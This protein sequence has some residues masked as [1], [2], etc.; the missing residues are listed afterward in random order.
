MKFKHYLTSRVRSLVSSEESQLF[1]PPGSIIIQLKV[2]LRN[3]VQ[4]EY[5]LLAILVVACFQAV[6]FVD[7]RYLCGEYEYAATRSTSPDMFTV[8]W[9]CIGALFVSTSS[10]NQAARRR[11]ACPK[12][13]K[14]NHRSNKRMWWKNDEFLPTRWKHWLHARKTTFS[15]QHRTGLVSFKRWLRLSF[16]VER[17]D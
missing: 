16:C 7:E 1:F 11:E 9:N 13:R 17:H 4:N 8:V 3:C 14:V 15:F 5:N 12:V 10:E 2:Q 6:L